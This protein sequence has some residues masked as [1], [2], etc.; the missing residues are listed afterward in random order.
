[1][2]FYFGCLDA[3]WTG[4]EGAVLGLDSLGSDTDRCVTLSASCRADNFNLVP[5]AMVEPVHR[6]SLLYAQSDCG[7]ASSA[8]SDVAVDYLANSRVTNSAERTS[9]NRY[10]C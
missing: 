2:L 8:L 10:E 7:P 3:S 1:M 5:G 9:L 4:S 6:I